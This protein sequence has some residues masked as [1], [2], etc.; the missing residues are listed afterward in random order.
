MIFGL[1]GKSSS[2]SKGSDPGS[3]GYSGVDRLEA[4]PWLAEF[5]VRTVAMV[6]DGGLDP[7]TLRRGGDAVPVPADGAQRRNWVRMQVEQALLHPAASSVY[8]MDEH[9]LSVISQAVRK[10]ADALVADGTL[11]DGVERIALSVASRYV[12]LVVHGPRTSTRILTELELLLQ[13]EDDHVVERFAG[14][15]VARVDSLPTDDVSRRVWIREML[16]GEVAAISTGMMSRP[17][18]A[19]AAAVSRAPVSHDRPADLSRIDL[20]PVARLAQVDLDSRAAQMASLDPE[21]VM[22]R[23]AVVPGFARRA[24]VLQLGSDQWAWLI[25]QS[26]DAEAV[27]RAAGLD[28]ADGAGS[29]SIVLADIR[30]PDTPGRMTFSA[31]LVVAGVRVCTVSS[32]GDGIIEADAWSDGCSPEDL[33]ALDLYVGVT[34]EPRDEGVTPDSLSL[35]I[36]DLVALEISVLAY[37]EATAR[38]VMFRMDPPGGAV[39]VQVPVPEGGSREGATIFVLSSHP[40]AVPLDTLA[41]EDAVMTWLALT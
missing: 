34:G 3:D 1:F 22:N 25:R 33:A 31:E 17:A 30:M 6:E 4:D 23:F 15:P 2:R 12:A 40:T 41:E 36:L 7:A 9:V 19:R 35:R 26:L 18:I 11:R 24:S 37:R 27:R 20:P 13:S 38:T 29:V 39:V 10:V 5:A 32:P 16:L 14:T 21:I 28:R 8:A